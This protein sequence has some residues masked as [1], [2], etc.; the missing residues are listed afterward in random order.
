M[1]KMIGADGREYGPISQEQLRQWVA[2][3]R[4]NA[5]TK[6]LPEG[7]TEWKPLGTLPEFQS[8]FSPPPIAPPA[9]PPTIASPQTRKTNSLAVVGLM[10]GILSFVFCCCYGFPFNIAGIVCSILALNQ[11]NARPDL[12][13]GKGIA[14]AGLVLSVAS[15]VLY[16]LLA[17]FGYATHSR[18]LM[19]PMRRL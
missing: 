10:F 18:G 11:I 12:Y 19:P 8:R 13:D 16:P 2:E 15:F 4:A 14:I 3:G 5:Q 1:Y 9:T 7:S 17:L 6:L